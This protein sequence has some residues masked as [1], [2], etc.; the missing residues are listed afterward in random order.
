MKQKPTK[1]R[2]K[3]RGRVKTLASKFIAEEMRTR[4]YPQQQAIAIGISRAKAKVKES[5]MVS[6]LKSMLAKY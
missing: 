5:T 3:L 4:K 2:T 1:K 6:R